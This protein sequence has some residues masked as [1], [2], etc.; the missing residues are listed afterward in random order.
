MGL[1]IKDITKINN[2]Q[3][4]PDLAT[5]TGLMNQI[6]KQDIATVFD[7]VRLPSVL[8]EACRYAVTGGGKRVRPLLALC[9]FLTVRQ[10]QGYVFCGLDDINDDIRQAMMAV[11]L[12]HCYSLIHDD[13]PCLDDDALRRGRP[14]CH[15][16]FGEATA[17]LAG[18]VLQSLAFE[19][20]GM[21]CL[22][23][24]KADKTLSMLALF[25][26]SARRMVSGQMRDVIGENQTLSQ[27]ELEC[28]HKDK[29]G[30]LIEVATLMGA[31]ASDAS[32]TQMHA[33]SVFAQKI[34]LAFQVQ[35]DVLDIT[36]ST[37]TLGKPA[38]SDEKLQKSTYVRLLG[39]S[40]AQDYAQSL[41]DE[42]L[43]SLSDFALDNPLAQLAKWLN[44]RKN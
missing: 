38:M 35:D 31:I 41:F 2:K 8:D 24:R 34:G 36:A 32:Q 29:T 28:I 22:T 15:I 40:A 11:E 20:L 10:A 44:R 42:A 3:C 5:I 4:Y 33:L 37:E 18:D 27:N 26:P 13:L 14:T 43:S 16:V 39:V 7:Y 12:L 30:A 1:M 25:A 6:L 23:R 9:A 17:L 19:S 21:E